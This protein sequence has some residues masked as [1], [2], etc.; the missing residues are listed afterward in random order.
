[1]N[2][3]TGFCRFLAVVLLSLLMSSGICFAGPGL[4]NYQGRLTD[5]KGNPVTYSVTITFTFWNAESGGEMLGGG[6]SDSDTVTPDRDGIYSTLVGDD[7]DNLIPESVFER[8][9]VWLNVNVNG[10]D[11]RPRKRLTSV[12]YSVQSETVQG[13]EVGRMS[14]KAAED[15]KEG[16]VV[17]LNAQGDIVPTR[18]P[19]V[20]NA[21]EL[22]RNGDISNSLR[23]ISLA[24][25]KVFLFYRINNTDEPWAAVVAAVTGMEVTANRANEVKLPG[26]VFNISLA[27]LDNSRIIITYALQRTCKAV[28]A[29]VDSGG[30][31]ALGTP[32]APFVIGNEFVEV[33]SMVT[34]LDSNRALIAYSSPAS[35]D[36]SPTESRAVIATISGTSVSYATPVTFS[37]NT[38]M[39]PYFCPVK[40]DE[41]K[42]AIGY[43][44]GA[45][46][47]VYHW[48]LAAVSDGSSIS[49]GNVVSV[50]GRVIPIAFARLAANK[51][52]W[53]NW[54]ADYELLR[55]RPLFVSGEALGMGNPVSIASSFQWLD[56][57]NLREDFCLAFSGAQAYPITGSGNSITLGD[58]VQYLGS[59][60]IEDITCAEISSTRV[61]VGYSEQNIVFLRVIDTDQAG[62]TRPYYNNRIGVAE[63]AAQAGEEC[64][65]T[66]PGGVTKQFSGLIPGKDYFVTEKG[67]SD[68]GVLRIGIALTPNKLLICR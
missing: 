46:P 7:P 32:S 8:K 6:F 9:P 31:I 66:I 38:P 11:L 57:A 40:V 58:P 44:G 18:L 51:A 13:A 42:V 64:L 4:L 53:A 43:A 19:G 65:V 21:F 10:E 29:S 59:S 16:D 39:S 25:D 20:G 15:I 47:G 49:L 17:V 45:L 60:N 35:P 22:T 34:A 62:G 48:R 67:I 26:V 33:E 36:S 37:T 41:N 50:P 61:L 54:D 5:G 12:G 24:E 28:V 23:A 2:K 68:T 27:K 30:S 55:I 14:F 1:M 52:V 63:R 56:I 3:S